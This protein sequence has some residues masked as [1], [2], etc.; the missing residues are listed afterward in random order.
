M[1]ADAV[2]LTSSKDL[3]KCLNLA[4]YFFENL[5]EYEKCNHIKQILDK[6]EFFLAENLEI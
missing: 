5:E 3:K 1:N 2:K 4:I 6:V